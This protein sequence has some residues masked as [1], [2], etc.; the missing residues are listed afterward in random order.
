M[1]ANRLNLD[2]GSEVESATDARLGVETGDGNGKT[3]ILVERRMRQYKRR[4]DA[5]D[6]GSEVRVE[7]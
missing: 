3:E 5:L 1:M 2:V 4:T 7:V 6:V